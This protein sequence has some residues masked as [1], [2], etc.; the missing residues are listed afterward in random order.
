MIKCRELSHAPKRVRLKILRIL[1]FQPKHSKILIK[2]VG[3]G[4]WIYPLKNKNDDN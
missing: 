4:I 1:G 2:P 3:A